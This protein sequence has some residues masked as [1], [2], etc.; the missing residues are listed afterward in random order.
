[1]RKSADSIF[2]SFF[3]IIKF[4]ISFHHFETKGGIVAAIVEAII[5]LFFIL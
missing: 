4:P 3:K 2:L 1:M 5:Y